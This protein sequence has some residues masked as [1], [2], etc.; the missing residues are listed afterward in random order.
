MNNKTLALMTLLLLSGCATTNQNNDGL[1]DIKAPGAGAIKPT[2]ATEASMLIAQS[3]TSGNP[4]AMIYAYRQALEFKPFNKADIYLNIAR[5]EQQ[6]NNN[7]Q[8]EE[9][10]RLAMASDSKRPELKESLALLLVDMKRHQEADTL[11]QEVISADRARLN[12]AS[13]DSAECVT[14]NQSPWRSYNGLGL[15]S[16]IREQG[17]QAREYYQCALKIQP[18]LAMLHTNL[19]FSYYLE[20]EYPQAERA[21]TRAVNQDPEY[22][23]AW[24]NLGLMYYRW[25][26]KSEALAALRKNGTQAEALN[27]LGYI[28]LMEG[29]NEEATGLFQRA[30][31]ASPRYYPRAVANLNQAKSMTTANKRR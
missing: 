10:Y 18:G 21:L 4:D 26:R 20:G 23:R 24:S 5:L 25:G 31:D 30:I 29:A 7:S 8:A 6:R 3:Q 16:D 9:A 27:D 15:L 12:A 14:D 1:S 13:A 28:A 11:L 22:R 17:E 19:G 2:N